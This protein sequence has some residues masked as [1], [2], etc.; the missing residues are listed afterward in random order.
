MTSLERTSESTNEKQ[1][2]EPLYLAACLEGLNGHK[3]A[4]E[5]CNAN[6][7]CLNIHQTLSANDEQH[8]VCSQLNR[9]NLLGSDSPLAL[10]VM[11]SK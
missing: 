6:L 9:M 4:Q 7:S 11:C 5:K 2:C 8:R 10:D 1:L 3:V